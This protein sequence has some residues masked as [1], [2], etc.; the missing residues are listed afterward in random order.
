MKS[1]LWSDGGSVGIE[2]MKTNI[3]SKSF[4]KEA[5]NMQVGWGKYLKC[6]D[7]LENKVD[8][9]IE[10]NLKEACWILY[11]EG[12]CS[13]IWEKFNDYCESR[14]LGRKKMIWE[15]WNELFQQWDR[16]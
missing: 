6:I 7:E 4:Y 12:H 2:V 15:C 10:I 9:H 13:A 8:N 11:G 1:V 3:K 14:K 5:E 16:K